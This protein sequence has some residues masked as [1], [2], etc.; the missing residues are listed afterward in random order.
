[1]NTAQSRALISRNVLFLFLIVSCFTIVIGCE[2]PG[3]IGEGFTDSGTAIKADTFMVDNLESSSYNF[4][5]GNLTH[6]S[7]GQFNDPLFGDMHTTGIIRPQLLSN[8]FTFTD[9]ANMKLRLVFD[10]IFVY[11]DS[12]QP[13]EYD[14]VELNQ[15]W[16]GPA[17]KLY[18]EPQ[19]T[20]SVVG[21]FT[22]EQEDSLDINLSENWTQLY[23]LQVLSENA[24]RDS[25]Y[26]INFPG[27]AIVPQNSGKIVPVD[28][29]A[30]KFIIENPEDDTVE[31]DTRDW[32]Y[33]LDRSNVSNTPPE[34]I[35]MHSTFENIISIEDLN[36]TRENLGSVNL[37]R[38]ELVLYED[39]QRLSNTISQASGSAT[40]ARI[41]NARLQLLE[42]DQVP[43]GLQTGSVLSNGTYNEEDGSY[44]FDITTFTNSILVDGLPSE[45]NFYLTLETNNGAIRSTLIHNEQGPEAKRPKLIVTY[46]QNQ[47]SSD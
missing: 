37:S 42:S 28:A 39:T 13:A 10:Q 31:V 38:V 47:A 12:T 45:L 18:D 11:G 43:I 41:T 23:R 40:R 16:R 9:S 2:D 27:L 33:S 44:R 30:S 26:R 25:L 24:N 15:V 21:S 29:Q 32:A 6:F 8:S 1:M 3:V 36:L 5:S 19:L 17:W 20:N 34:T 35:K 22:V 4:Y 46:V 14:I 7:I